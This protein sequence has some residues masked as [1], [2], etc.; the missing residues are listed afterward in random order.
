MAVI[1]TADVARLKGPLPEKL[2]KLKRAKVVDGL[3]G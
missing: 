3:A 2:M 1:D